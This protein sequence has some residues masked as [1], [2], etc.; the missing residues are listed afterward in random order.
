MGHEVSGVGIAPDAQKI[1]VVQEWPV[2]QTVKEL[3]TFLGFAKVIIEDSLKA[4]PR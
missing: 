3:R 1:A 2:P 4:L